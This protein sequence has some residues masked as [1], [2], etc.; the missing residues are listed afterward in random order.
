[1]HKMLFGRR[2]AVL[3]Y[4][5]IAFSLSWTGAFIVAAPALIRGEG[6]PK[7][8]GI[9][10]FPLM[11]LGPC[12]ASLVLTRF[13]YGAGAVKRLLSRMR[14]D[15]AA[16]IW[17][18]ALTIPPFLIW[19]VLFSMS[20]L[21]SP[22]FAPSLFWQGILFGV[23]AGFLEEIGW[24]GFA[25]PH[26]TQG[27]NVFRASVLLGV[28][29]GIWHLP[30][31][32]YLGAATPHGSYLL[33]FFLAFT[34][35]LTGLRVFIAWVYANTG[36]LLLAQLIHVSSTG[37]LVAFSPAGVTASGEA[38]WYLGYAAALWVLAIA[39]ALRERRNRRTG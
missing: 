31:I 15:R 33:P 22:R 26:M 17:Y 18:L 38:L 23:P 5:A 11:I 25:L 7:Q 2:R 3:L 27:R 1:M 24:T 16:P 12:I 32:D 29:W 9:F 35:A 10:M 21:V 19:G 37:S 39:I 20:R 28:V 34:A 8:N 14:P 30:V 13:A 36:S 4:F 6:I